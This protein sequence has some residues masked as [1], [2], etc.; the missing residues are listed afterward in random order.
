MSTIDVVIPITPGGVGAAVDISALAAKKTFVFA[1]VD[2]GPVELQTSID[3]VEFCTVRSVTPNETDIVL[4]FAGMFMRID[5]SKGGAITSAVVAAERARIRAVTLPA[6]AGPGV[7]GAAVDVALLGTI[8]TAIVTSVG[9]GAAAELQISQD[10]VS[11]AQVMKSFT[12][13]ETWESE[14]FDAKFARVFARG[15][16]VGHMDLAAQDS[17][18]DA[19][20]SVITGPFTTA[21]PHDVECGDTAQVDTTANVVDIQL[22]AVTPGNAGCDITVKRIAGANDHRLLTAGADTVDSVAGP[23]DVIDATGTISLTL[24]S[25]GVSNWMNV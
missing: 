24:R 21:G 15:G 18:L 22:P 4:T 7:G 9:D 23:I 5:A 17:P 14:C 3:G 8:N 13:P 20:F 16:T 10:G 12:K 11:W 25:D 2:G 1:G 19:S 6:P